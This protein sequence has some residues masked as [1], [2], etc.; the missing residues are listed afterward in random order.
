MRNIRT[1]LAIERHEA[2]Q[3]A[4]PEGVSLQRETL[5]GA[6]LTKI[7]V[8]SAAAAR[9]LQKPCGV[10]YTAALEGFPD[11]QSLTDGRLQAV[12][13]ALLALLPEEGPVLVAGLGNLQITPDALGPKCA[14]MVLATRHID[15]NTVAA[16]SLPSLREVSVLTPGVTGQTGFEAVEIIAGMTEKI[17]PAAVIAVDALA[18]AGTGRL[19]RTVQ[20]SSAGIEPGSGVG[21]ARMALNRETLGVPVIAVGVPTVM[22]AVSLARDVFEEPEDPPSEEEYAGMIVTPRDIDTV[23]DSAARL[24]ALSINCALQKNLKPKEILGLM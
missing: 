14:S 18:A 7:T 4:P 15:R 8:H 11:S 10:Y 24:I 12:T 16:L 21:N 17:R 6:V 9:A 20:L 2:L 22:D 13:K 5:D 1:D 23:I 19:C 3:A